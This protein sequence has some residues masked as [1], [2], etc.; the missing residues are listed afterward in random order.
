MKRLYTS[1]FLANHS[2]KY[3]WCKATKA[4][5]EKFGRVPDEFIEGSHISAY[6]EGPSRR[7]YKNNLPNLQEYTPCSHRFHSIENR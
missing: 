1:T 7:R 6:W 2:F 3:K 5:T 4:D